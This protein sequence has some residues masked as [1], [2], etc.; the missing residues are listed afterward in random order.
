MIKIT[1]HLQPQNVHTL[2]I[3]PVVLAQQ[4]RLALTATAQS[5][6]VKHEKVM[7][8]FSDCHQ[9]YNTAD[10]LTS[11]DADVL[12]MN[13]HTILLKQLLLQCFIPTGAAIVEF[14]A[15]YRSTFPEATV[16]PKM[17]FLEDH[18]V[19]WIKKWKTGFGFLGEQGAGSI[20]KQINA[21][22][23]SCNCIPNKVERLHHMMEAHHTQVCPELE[24]RPQG[25]VR[26]KKRAL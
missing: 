1:I 22:E 17:H 19:P 12:G 13:L 26:K 25:L 20:H 3:A 15:S 4:T 14:L 24:E 9:M 6:C 2:C 5:I 18:A 7:G 11:T 16:L 8:L 23:R 10:Q 21:L